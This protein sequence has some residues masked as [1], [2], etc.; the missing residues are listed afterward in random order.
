MGTLLCGS[1]AS[2]A[3][4]IEVLHREIGCGVVEVSFAAP[5]GSEEAKQQAMTLFANEVIP[6]VKGL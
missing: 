2:V 4:Q 5:Q 3:E 1:P 6:A